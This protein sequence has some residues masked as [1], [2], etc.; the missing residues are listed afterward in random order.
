M[1]LK[2][3]TILISTLALAGAV[4][5]LAT[6][7]SAQSGT[8]E[9]PPEFRILIL[10]GNITAGGK[11]I[12]DGFKLT[13][14][15]GDYETRPVTTGSV[16]SGRYV[17]LQ[18][19]AQ[20]SKEG[21]TIEFWLDGQVR[22]KETEYFGPRTPEPDGRPCAGCSWSLPILRAFNLTFDTAPMPTPTPTFT[23]TATFTPTSTP[24]VLA[25]TFYS[26]RAIAGNA[27]PPDGTEIFARIGDYASGTFVIKGGRFE[28]F[29]DPVLEKYK[30][31]P[32]EFYIGLLKARQTPTFVGGQTISDLNLGFPALP[33]PT[34]TPTPTQTPTP[35]PTPTPTL[36]PTPT[37]TPIPTATPTQTPTSTPIPTPTPTPTPT[38]EPTRTPTPTATNTPSPTPT[39]TPTPLPDLGATATAEALILKEQNKG[40]MCNSSGG[41]ASAG[42]LALFAIPLTL[43]A[44]QR[45]K[46]E[47][48]LK[49]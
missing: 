13:A 43:A 46:K 22:A 42:M 45:W 8:P 24:V 19:G 44:W 7:T 18:V 29:V 5:L 25:P 40:G 48:T 36:T 38:P 27:T 2:L 11:P 16:S 37:Y 34:P 14:R 35:T 49:S 23:P 41:Q 39:A 31:Q 20:P 33:T 17:G 9:R 30:G 6:R 1:K 4:S 26:G 12:A 47:R 10:Q 3:V 28:V 32:V 15:I 21:G